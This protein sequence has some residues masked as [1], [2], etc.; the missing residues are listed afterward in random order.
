ME[1][2]I[3][4]R[5]AGELDAKPCEIPQK[6]GDPGAGGVTRAYALRRIS[7]YFGW[8]TPRVR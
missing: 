6:K 4:A 8:M 5:H 1:I 3:M 2:S 7:R